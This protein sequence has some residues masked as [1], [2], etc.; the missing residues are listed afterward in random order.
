LSSMPTAIFASSVITSTLVAS[1]IFTSTITGSLSQFTALSSL[2]I[3][4]SSF[5]SATRQ[6]TP[7]FITF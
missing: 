7:M 6:A 1:S 3:N 4:V 5:Y 2:T